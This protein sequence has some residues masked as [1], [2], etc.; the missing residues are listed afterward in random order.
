M[1]RMR[2]CGRARLR[3]RTRQ[4]ASSPSRQ[5]PGCAAWLEFDG[6]CT[7][8]SIMDGA[9]NVEEHRFDKPDGV[10]HGVALRAYDAKTDQWAIW[11]VDGRNPHGALDPPTVGRFDNGVGTFYWD[12]VVN[13]QQIR[14]RL[15]GRKSRRS[16]RTGNKPTPPM[17]AKV[18]RSTGAWIS[19]A[20]RRSNQQRSLFQNPSIFLPITD[21]TVHVAAGG[22][23]IQPP[24]PR[25]PDIHLPRCVE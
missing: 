4:L 8:R 12:G 23:C 17:A 22:F 10:T 16:P 19:G 3:L 5:A 14:T 9:G 15:S 2:F 6:T 25:V 11:W 1:L 20:C 18:G 24:G 7:V 21:L 13:G